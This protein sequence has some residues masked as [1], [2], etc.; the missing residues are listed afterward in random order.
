[1]ECD[2]LLE[3]FLPGIMIGNENQCDRTCP[4]PAETRDIYM[5]QSPN[6]IDGAAA[7]MLGNRFQHLALFSTRTR[8][9]SS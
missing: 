7:M 9:G 3:M 6:D 5:Q 8:V 4:C 2:V 1:M